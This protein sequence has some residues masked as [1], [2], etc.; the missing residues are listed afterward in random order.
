MS[1]VLTDRERAVLD[2]VMYGNMIDAAES[3]TLAELL[4]RDLL[5]KS[6]PDE[7]QAASDHA[8]NLAAALAELVLMVANESDISG[9]PLTT[10]AAVVVSDSRLALIEFH[11]WVEATP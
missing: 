5:A 3:A 4:N 9:R 7:R 8:F 11:A 10:D 6:K 2:R 1:Y